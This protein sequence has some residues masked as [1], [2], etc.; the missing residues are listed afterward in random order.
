MH[1]LFIGR[2][3]ELDSLSKLFDDTREGRVGFA[4]IDGP[5]G[6]GKT[7]LIDYFIA[8]R[9]AATVLFAS[10]EQ[11]EAAVPYAV[12]DQLLRQAG[13]HVSIADERWHQRQDQATLDP[14]SAGTRL[15]DLLG[16]SQEGAPLLIVIDDAQWVDV[17]S[18]RALVFALRRLVADRVMAIVAVRTDDLP[19]LP[20]GLRRLASR[21]NGASITMQPFSHSELVQLASLVGVSDFPARAALRL[22]EHTDGNP[23][24][25]SALLR[26]LPQ[27][28]W[29]GPLSSLPPPRSYE[30]MVLGRLNACSAQ[31]RAL[32]E[33]V[34]VLGRRSRLGVVARV[35][36]VTE[37]LAA[38]D[39]AIS[40]DLLVMHDDLD[41]SG[42]FEVSFRHPLTQAAVYSQIAPGRRASLNLLA[43]EC[44][45]DDLARLRHRAAAM[46]SA[47]DSLAAELDEFAAHETA[48]GAWS[49]AAASLVQASR[50]S[51][52]EELAKQRLLRAVDSML[53]HGDIAAASS[54]EEVVTSMPVS[55]LRD[56]VLGFMALSTHRPVAA[57]RLLQRA[58]QHC[59]P[60]SDPVLCGTIARRNA[61]HFLYRLR[62]AE[63]IQW[64]R[65]A[66][67]FAGE[68][69]ESRVL[70]EMLPL[71]VGAAYAG[72]LPD[73]LAQ[74]ALVDPPTGGEPSH[75]RV[76]LLRARGWL[77]LINDELQGAKADLGTEA[78]DALKLGSLGTAA[79]ALGMLARVEYQLGEWDEALLHAGRATVMLSEL[80]HFFISIA[81][82]HGVAVMAARGDWEAAEEQLALLPA[83][84]EDYEQSIVAGGIAR[85]QLASA[86]GDFERI[87]VVL[88]PVAELRFSD[89]VDEPG[90]WPWQH[91][92]A[93]ALVMTGQLERA[94][95]FLAP[96]EELA[97]RRGRMSSISKLARVRG[98][99]LAA[100]GEHDAAD[101]SFQL[102]LDAAE[103]TQIKLDIAS[104]QLAWGQALRRRG[105]RR[106]AA[107]RL[108]R[109]KDGFT[110]LGARPF[111]EIC[112]VELGGCGL[113][114]ARRTTPDPARL[115]PQELAVAR[116]VAKGLSNREVAAELV[117][118]VR[119]IEFHLTHIYAKLEVG[120]RAQLVAL[121]GGTPGLGGRD[122]GVRTWGLHGRETRSESP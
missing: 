14:V 105:Q 60:R 113:A 12:V 73:G 34:A 115:T 43:A 110:E 107:E 9:P 39:A 47:D 67:A 122:S 48:R 27:S 29:Q 42:G 23:L 66:L 37:P 81:I 49:R 44:V 51:T 20:D 103:R 17:Y 21:D 56:C 40:Q 54:Y 2:E 31:T 63:A 93:E 116:L 16:A 100:L 98:K 6:I 95:A 111:E 30:A 26:E 121:A 104:I 97:Q 13:S 82:A 118:S 7:M 87:L 32:V 55:P 41:A 91:L 101:Q 62:G 36:G 89:G 69:V 78:R 96:H 77:R 58:W 46:A 94:A 99:L 88:R 57:E 45:D 106:A 35:G 53:Y 1:H 11:G 117:L 92:W 74:I 24:H 64:S 109:A 10:G 3:A 25:A 70:A 112:D 108:Q 18:L 72:D 28:V 22:R 33:A 76:R 4:L 85:A 84:G 38:L 83:G 19:N 8:Q 71:G 65:R 50:L 114:P 79:F 52:T 61:L 86:R 59:D 75:E 15:L 120:S 119:T 68:H 80:G 5:A 90:C 102:A